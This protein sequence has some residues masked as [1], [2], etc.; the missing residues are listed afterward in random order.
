MKQGRMVRY[1]KLPESMSDRAS[2]KRASLLAIMSWNLLYIITLTMSFLG[3]V[4][5]QSRLVPTML[6]I[7]V[8]Q[9]YLSSTLHC[10]VLRHIDGL[11]PD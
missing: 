2:V 10:E 6:P 11:L 8:S 9:W 7:T 1:V 3:V 4:S 5:T